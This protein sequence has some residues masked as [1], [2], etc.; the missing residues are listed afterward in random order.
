MKTLYLVGALLL[1][2][3]GVNAAP[4]IGG[5][6]SGGIPG[7]SSNAVYNMILIYSGGTNTINIAAGTGITVETN[8]PTLNTI[9]ANLTTNAVLAMD[10]FQV[11]LQRADGT[12]SNLVAAANTDI[13]RGNVLLTARNTA[14]AG[15][16]INVGPGSYF[17]NTNLIK[18]KVNWNFANGANVTIYPT[19]LV[20]LFE[21]S[22]LSITSSITGQGNFTMIIPDDFEGVP[23]N[24]YS[25]ILQTQGSNTVVNFEFN[26][27]Y[28]RMAGDN[29]FSTLYR[30]ISLV[31][32][33]YTKVK[34]SEVKCDNGGSGAASE[35]QGISWLRGEG[36][37]DVD[38]ILT[39]SGVA[40][41]LDQD[42][43]EVPNAPSSWF[44][45]SKFICSTNSWAVW[46][47]GQTN[48]GRVWI[49]ADEIRS[50]NYV[51]LSHWV[52]GRLYVNALKISNNANDGNTP[53]I[54]LHGNSNGSAG[55]P[56]TW[57]T[58]QKVTSRSVF[59]GDYSDGTSDNYSTNF[60]NVQHFEG[61]TGM[62][63]G[64]RFKA[65]SIWYISGSLI[66]VPSGYAIVHQGGDVTFDGFTITAPT[67]AY[68][69]GSGL[70]LQ[71]IVAMC[72][73]T[74]SIT[75]T[76]AQTVTIENGFT[77]NKGKNSNITF[78][79]WESL[80]SLSVYG[81]QTN[82]PLAGPGYRL[83]QADANGKLSAALNTN[84]VTGV[85]GGIVELISGA[86]TNRWEAFH[87]PSGTIIVT[88]NVPVTGMYTVNLSWNTVLG[89]L[90]ANNDSHSW[91]SIYWTDPNDGQVHVAPWSPGG[92]GASAPYDTKYG[93]GINYNSPTTS[94]FSNPRP[95]PVF[96]CK[97][98]T[99]LSVSNYN[100][101]S[102]SSGDDLSTNFV[103]V[104]I[105]GRAQ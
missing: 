88:T 104:S 95:N 25:A 4:V 80:N 50:E 43:A 29:L 18:D 87:A 38:R 51:A 37:L 76:N 82:A 57:L 21:D 85:P 31:T 5:P 68:V 79:G 62:T 92:G 40:L 15:D 20:G 16:T 41:N 67:A 39:Q 45:R 59:L 2:S 10:N 84:T 6:I 56:S 78:D 55:N 1:A 99:S 3:L 63:S 97:A 19:N 12:I 60:I 94:D 70:K 90:G 52:N 48:T 74:D 35:I 101:N 8:S 72:S 96:Y 26:N 75:A 81:Q 102:W 13:A 100:D 54:E 22:F 65:N 28:V 32:G 34:G 73:G 98:G 64:F 7:L 53:A 46:H 86:V 42:A 24:G 89:T 103:R 105:W 58:A 61:L 9:S 83:V 93:D 77:S 11:K 30:G 44:V 33:R 17:V 91:T 23:M 66:S 36:A 69:T 47:Y 49:Q 14:A 27:I 71:N